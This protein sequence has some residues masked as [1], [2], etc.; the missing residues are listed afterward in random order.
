MS[1]AT[2]TRLINT[3][4]AF[5]GSSALD[6]RNCAPAAFRSPSILLM[7]SALTPRAASSTW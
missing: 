7:L 6:G 2:S 1:A 5:G 4:Y 3:D